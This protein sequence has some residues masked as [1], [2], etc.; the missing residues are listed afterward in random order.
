VR[1][2]NWG[3][4]EPNNYQGIELC[5]EINGDSSMLW[6]DRHCDYLYGWICQIRK[7]ITSSVYEY[8]KKRFSVDFSLNFK[9]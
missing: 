6:N 5:A 9:K 7:G 8:N 3:F 2:E 4:G 1:Y